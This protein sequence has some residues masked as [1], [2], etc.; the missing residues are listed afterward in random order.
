MSLAA[1]TRIGTYEITGPLGAGGM[2]EV[3]RAKDLRLRRDVALTVLPETLA[4]DVDHLP[5]FEREAVRVRV[6]RAS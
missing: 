1:G 2:S 3:Y 6:R 4:R 5:R